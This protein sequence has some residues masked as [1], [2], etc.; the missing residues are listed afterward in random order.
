[1][2]TISSN[3]QRRRSPN[4]LVALVVLLVCIIFVAFFRNPLSNIFLRV[5]SPLFVA[6][7]SVGGGLSGIFAQFSS[8]ASLE[9]QNET[10]RAALAS[11]S[12]ALADRDILYQQNL[13]IKNQFGRDTA[14]HALLAGV[15]MRPP[16]IPYD[17]LL[18]DA[19]SAQGVTMG[20]IVSAGGTTA[21]GRIT[22]VYGTQS[23][24]TLFSAAG[25]SYQALLQ[26][27]AQGGVSVPLSFVG[28]GGGSMSAEVPSGTRV[29]LGD[30]VILAGIAAPFVGSV[31]HIDVHDGQSFET[32]YIELPVDLFSLQYIEVHLST[33]TGLQ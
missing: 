21:I 15:L 11:T 12:A 25:E 32:V 26:L 23:R 8:K 18:I 31:S 22:S 30:H 2:T 27:S 9:T 24:A 28:Q 14:A 17:T 3:R 4:F 6:R 29:T 19:G 20:D 16:N 5:T 1:M 13:F 7:D 33:Q 10:L